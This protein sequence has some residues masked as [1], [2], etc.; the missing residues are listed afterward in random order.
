MTETTIANCLRLLGA[1]AVLAASAIPAAA[2]LG[3]PGAP[4]ASPRNQA[5]LRLEGQLAAID[6]GVAAF[7]PAKAEQIRRYEDAAGKQQ[8]EL[9][10]LTQ[11]SRRM[12][13]QGGGF[14]A[15]FSGQSP[16][17]GPLNN[18]IQQVRANLDRFLT[19]IQ[20]LQGNSGEREAQRRSLL[21]ALG[22]ND[23]GPQYRQYANAG[24]GGFFENLFGGFG[25]SGDTA[26]GGTYRTLCVRTCDGFY[27]PISFSTVPNRFADDERLCQRLCPASEAVLYSHR[28]PGEDVSRAVSAGGRLY[29][30]L[31]MAFSYRK[32]LNPS[33]S[34]RAPGQ[35]WAEA[36]R[37]VDDQTIERGDIVV[38]EERARL[39]S[40]PRTDAQGRPVNLDPTPPRPGVPARGPTAAPAASP[41]ASATAPAA[42]AA[43]LPASASPAAV[44][45]AEE[46]RSKRKVRA[47]GPAFYPVR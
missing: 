13:C 3:F 30:E 10:R 29:S 38:T 42:A 15:L 16:Q 26:A 31:P 46:D 8:A 2:Q 40:Q 20:R 7:D 47:V 45:P 21:V 37:Q 32:Q 44:P 17:C 5:C 22:Q 24:P 27:F 9:D 34:C 28:N 35:S 36:L 39:L 41:A 12:G 33:C 43:K 6:R 14:F 18:Q 25:N 1:A 23:C 11:Q 19:E 4:Q